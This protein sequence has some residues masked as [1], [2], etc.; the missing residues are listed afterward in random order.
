MLFLISKYQQIRTEVLWY[1]LVVR[2]QTSMLCPTI[3]SLD[4]LM[5]DLWQLSLLIFSCSFINDLVIDKWC[6]GYGS[7]CT[8]K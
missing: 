4:Q 2:K 6:S 8:V 1:Y 7:S 3:F 5:L